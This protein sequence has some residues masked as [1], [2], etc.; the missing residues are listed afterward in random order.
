MLQYKVVVLSNHYIIGKGIF[1]KTDINMLF[2]KIEYAV[3][4][5]HWISLISFVFSYLNFPVLLFLHY[6]FK[7]KEISLISFN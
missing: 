4:F 5:S 2:S 6:H 7:M 3:I 1:I